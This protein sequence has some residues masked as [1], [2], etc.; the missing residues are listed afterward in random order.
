MNCPK[1]GHDRHRVR[2][3]V[4]L[5]NQVKRLRT[6]RNCGAHFTTRERLSSNRR[7][8]GIE[9]PLDTLRKAR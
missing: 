9:K 2:R 5:A 1:C 3:T 4:H 6:C 7:P 8:F